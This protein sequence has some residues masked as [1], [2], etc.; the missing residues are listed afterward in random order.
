MRRPLAA[1]LL[2]LSTA[3]AA[4]PATAV[5]TASAE[6]ATPATPPVAAAPSEAEETVTAEEARRTLDE[7]SAVLAGRTAA[8]GAGHGERAEAT[9]LMRDLFVALPTLEGAERRQ[10]EALLARPTDGARD[11]QGDGYSVPTT[12]KCTSNFCLHYVTSSADQPTSRAWVKKNVK[13]LQKVWRHEVKKMGYRPPAKDGRRGGNGKFDVYLKE[14]GSKGLYGYCVPE[15]RVAGRKWVASGYC[16]LDNDFAQAQ[17]GAP[18]AQSLKVTAAHEFFHAIQFAYDYNEDRWLM[19]ST[20]TWMEERVADGVDDN[21]QYLSASQVK[22]PASSLDVFQPSGFAQY[23]NW[24]LWEYL[25]RRFGN[26]IVKKVWNKAGAFKGAPN[27]YSTKALRKA[28][29]GKGGGFASV[30][31][32][33]AASNTSPARYYPEGAAWPKAGFSK[34]VTLSKS[35]RKSST[36]VRINHLAAR[37]VGVKPASDLAGK[38]WKLRITVNA[39]NRSSSPA[40]HVLVRNKKGA[41]SRKTI[42]LTKKGY[43]KKVVSFNAK[44]VSGV[45]ITLANASTRFKCYKGTNLSCRGKA[46]DQN[47]QF[48]VKVTA[49][50]R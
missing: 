37:N 30:F 24:T 31:A 6:P 38:K 43:G 11:P 12:K 42:S 1:V 9:L 13:V 2:A 20:A 32:A 25:G 8:R 26:G 36:T 44:K 10:A 49:F 16:V 41:W 27:M 47:K 28:I 14:L 40:V 21:R 45:T 3:L 23:G 34:R 17:F 39:P 5:S 18:P 48:S 4:L 50:K 46:R 15:Y 29:G 19:E 35:A 33:Y 7:A 22:Q